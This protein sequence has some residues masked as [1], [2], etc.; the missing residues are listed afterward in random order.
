MIADSGSLTQQLTVSENDKAL[1]PFLLAPDTSAAEHALAQLIAEHVAPRLREIVGYKLRAYSNR[2]D[3]GEEVADIHSEVLSLLLA[4]LMDLRLDPRRRP[5]RNLRGYIAVTAYNVCHDHLRRKYPRRASLKNKLRYTMTRRPEFAFWERNTDEWAGGLAG[6]QAEGTRELLGESESTALRDRLGE[7]TGAYLPR[8]T[9]AGLSLPELLLA[10]FHWAQRP[11]D[12][13]HLVALVAE[14]QGLRED[15]PAVLSA[16]NDED[17]RARLEQLPDPRESVADELAQQA[18]LKLLWAEV[19]DMKPTHRFALLLNL[20]DE[21]GGS[22]LDLFLF[23]GV[24]SF[25][26]LAAA[27]QMAEEELAALWNQLPLDD[28]KIAARLGITRQ[29]VIN[30]R[31]SARER[32]TKRMDRMTT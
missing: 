12:L 25:G 32:L 14:L 29:Q 18:Y 24:T 2:T 17:L 22:A 5:I 16:E 1:L 23:T 30:L 31:K 10:V 19:Q 27:L 3:D 20:R 7:F 26:E 28:L 4:R 8:G 6:W 13:D 9:A 15:T 11:M 21:Q